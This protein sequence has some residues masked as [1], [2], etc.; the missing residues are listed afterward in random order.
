MSA[1][2]SRFANATKS[3][4][5]LSLSG[6]SL[7]PGLPFFSKTAFVVGSRQTVFELLSLTLSAGGVISI[8]LL[9]VELQLHSLGSVLRLPRY[10]LIA[11]V[12][13]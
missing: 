7:T 13:N 4:S 2:D 11:D 10:F 5:N 6:I 1:L 12:P 3:W 8:K 9:L